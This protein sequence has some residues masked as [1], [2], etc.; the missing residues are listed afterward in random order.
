MGG[1][2]SDGVGLWST[3]GCGGRKEKEGGEEGKE[4]VKEKGGEGRNKREKVRKKV[5]KERWG[6]RKGESQPTTADMLVTHVASISLQYLQLA[7]C[8]WLPVSPAP[9]ASF[10]HLQ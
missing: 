5:K 4:E 2:T 8:I 10:C 6:T 1:E 7:T 9:P 3:G